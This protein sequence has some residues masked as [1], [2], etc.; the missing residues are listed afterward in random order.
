MTKTR[1][2]DLHVCARH[3]GEVNTNTNNPEETE[4]EQYSSEYLVPAIVGCRKGIFVPREL[5]DKLAKIVALFDVPDLT[6][7]AFVT[8]VLVDHLMTN[9]DVINELTNRGN[10]KTAL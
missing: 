10:I 4:I 5:V 1:F 6:I 7:G 9:R 8:N 2:C 3:M